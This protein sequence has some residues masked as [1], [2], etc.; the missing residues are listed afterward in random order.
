M[1]VSAMLAMATPA[2]AT[3]AM[4]MAPTPTTTATPPTPMARGPLTPSPFAPACTRPTP[5]ALPLP[6]L[7]AWPMHPPMSTTARGLL[8]PSLR[9]MLSFSM[10]VSAM[11]A[12]DTPASAMPA[13]A[14]LVMAM[15][16]TPTTTATP[17]MATARGPLMPS[18][19][20]TMAAA[21]AM[22]DT[23]ATGATATAGGMAVMVMAAGTTGK[24]KNRRTELSRLAQ[25]IFYE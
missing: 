13:S 16:H 17:P 4:A 25:A 9:L 23:V 2:S 12:T 20:P 15:A 1:E 11:L 24:L 7:T 6:T 22:V 10:E 8:T 21:T 18:L 3:P 5:A 19:R 14:M